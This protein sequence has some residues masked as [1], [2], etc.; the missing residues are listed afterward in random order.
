MSFTIARRRRE[1][2]IRAA[3]GAGPR[4]VLAAVLRRAATQ[5]ATGIVL[6]IAFAGAL[7]QMFEGGRADV[8]GYFLLA[9][10]AGFMAVV[11][12]L[13]TLGPARRALN[14]QPKEALTSQ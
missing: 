1:I 11:G 5:I 13:A 2:G 8:R 12:L 10:V 6:G 9:G 14:I 7:I 3:L 4:R